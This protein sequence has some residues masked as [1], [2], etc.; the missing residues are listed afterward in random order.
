M[1]LTV[2]PR[3]FQGFVG[4]LRYSRTVPYSSMLVGDVEGRVRQMQDADDP[5]ESWKKNMNELCNEWSESK[6]R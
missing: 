1:D 6:S 5:R 4:F 3:R 2:E